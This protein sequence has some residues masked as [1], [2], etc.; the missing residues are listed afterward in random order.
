MESSLLIFLIQF[1]TITLPI[2]AV[3]IGYYSSKRLEVL[4]EN[5]KLKA[6]LFSQYIQ[7]S[8]KTGLDKDDKEINIKY[9][10]TVEKLCLY[11]NENV[12]TKIALLHEGFKKNKNFIETPDGKRIYFELV[13]A[14]REDVGLK[15]ENLNE[16]KIISVLEL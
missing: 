6:D 15:V 5:R 8:N 9:S 16:A 14:M 11:A 7:I 13:I 4:R 3:I 2:I 1:L 12:L 10:E